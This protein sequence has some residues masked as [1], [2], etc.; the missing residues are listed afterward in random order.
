MSDD[1]IAP[2]KTSLRALA[3]QRRSAFVTTLDP[4]AHRLAFKVIPSPLAR[5]I[6]DANV[7]ALYMGLDDEAP[8]QRMAAQLLTMGKS[9]AL[10]RVL[11]RLG[12]M[13]F[14][15]WRP[16]DTLI[17]GPF[18]TSHPEP[19]DGPVTPDVIIAPLVGFDRDMNRLGQGGGYYDRAF[20][21]FPDA[22]RVGVAWSVQEMETVP[23]DPW[24]L[25]LD[26]IMTEVE[27]IEGEGENA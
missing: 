10:P 5:R 7:V 19:G 1:S 12:S 9:V 21:R 23:A 17:P 3:R 6:A 27:L 18:R 13:D 15:N 4:L 22:L 14:L 11:D 16:E 20:A 2:D 24:D 25:P 8:A 26:I